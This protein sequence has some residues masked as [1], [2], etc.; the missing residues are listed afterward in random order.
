MMNIICAWIFCVIGA[1]VS[2]LAVGYAVD[3]II[4]HF[5]EKKDKK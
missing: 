1:V 3:R 2:I 4:I 5:K